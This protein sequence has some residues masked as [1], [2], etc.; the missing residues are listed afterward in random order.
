[1]PDIP[2]RE[3]DRLVYCSQQEVLDVSR[4]FNM[5]LYRFREWAQLLDGDEADGEVFPKNVWQLLNNFEGEEIFKGVCGHKVLRLKFFRDLERCMRAP[6]QA[7]QDQDFM[8]DVEN[9][10]DVRQDKRLEL[11]YLSR[12]AANSDILA[13]DSLSSG[14]ARA[15]VGTAGEISQEDEIIKRYRANGERGLRGFVAAVLRES[16]WQL[17]DGHRNTAKGRQKCYSRVYEILHPSRR[18]ARFSAAFS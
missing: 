6:I 13:S 15:R 18:K 2:P 16:G 3:W 12:I 1:M 10:E 11:E 17:R 9:E 7:P 14:Q 4:A 8:P 5:L